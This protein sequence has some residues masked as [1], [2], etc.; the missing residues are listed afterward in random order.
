M[1]RRLKALALASALLLLGADAARASG[2]GMTTSWYVDQFGGEA[3]D[4]SRLYDGR[5]G[6]VMAR[7]PRPQLY[8]AWRLLHGQKVGQAA[9]EALSTPCCDPPW[10]WR[11][12]ISRENVGVDGWLKARALVPG[13]PEVGYITTEREGANYTTI[14]NC[15]DEAFD[16]ASATLKDRAAKYGADSPAVKAWL[17]TQDAVF[18]ACHA[19]GAALPV[20]IADAPAWLKADRAYQEAAFDLYQG[21][22]SDAAVRFAAIAKDRGSPWRPLA[23]YLRTRALVRSAVVEKTA[24]AF[25]GARAAIGELAKAPGGTFG[26]GEAPKMRRMLD[27]R[28]RPR[29]LMAE[30]EKE[31]G[32]RDAVSD[33]AVGFRDYANLYD[34]GTAPSEAMD[35]IATIRA[36][37]T[38]DAAEAAE[39][40]G[41]AETYAQ[42][43][44]RTRREALAHARQRWGATHDP[45]W[46][47][48]G[49]ALTDPGA[50]EAADLA[51]AAGKVPA[52]SPA[53]LS[54]QYH[55]T[56]LTMGGAGA[57]ATRARL[58]AVLARRDLSVNDRNLFLAQRAQVAADAAEFARFAQRR[59]ICGDDDNKGG[60]VRGFWQADAV[61][62]AGVY[63]GEGYAGALGFG[64]D[65][66]A[67]IDRLPLKT[68][69]ALGRDAQLPAR[70]RLDIALTN[71]ARA[72]VLGD[73]A[74]VDGLMGDLQTLL[75]Q[76]AAEWRAIRA[77]PAGPQKRF[78]EFFVLAKV[79]G[80]RTDLVDYIRPE[81]TVAQFQEPW[82]NWVVLP[83]GRPVAPVPPP[84][85]L[86]Q[87]LGT[88]V[89]E[90]D[91]DTRTDLSCL[92]EC[93]DG[94]APL[95]LPDFA[96]AG[97]A[98]A[99]T[100]RG[101]FYRIRP[102][103]GETPEALPPGA[104]AV[105]DEMLAFAR[106]NP[107]HPQVPEA[108]YWIIRAGR[109]GGSHEH[110]GR[111]AFELL[112]KA[113][114]G[115]VWAKRSPYYY[116]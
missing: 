111:R 68:R 31:L 33:I 43:A 49:L 51:E 66:R 112:H 77:A 46:L 5:L 7:S 57:A 110:S 65:A 67:V 63:D 22:N 115:S 3:A 89:S 39:R 108:L 90:D 19:S 4:L 96:A 80:L 92:G 1:A 61:Q 75:P 28:D 54:A 32:Q 106:A 11:Y 34:K 27:F 70:L 114:P 48:A 50:P 38:R 93:G 64:E 102:S 45:A 8:I 91:P 15:F 116:D 12:D 2:P 103:Y 97:A 9:G 24:D 76:L 94:V 84:L 105:W 74:T 69:L 101:Y 35:W 14:A 6:V 113:Y 59:R 72:V 13:A 85:A 41:A 47:V 10:R 30:L 100:E 56:R 58:D 88:G 21:R 25:A 18:D 60:C 42:L 95:R 81:G 107:K 78:A 44:A 87:Q 16:T 26:Q 99:R 109:W 73:H 36:A 53:W 86:Y 40:E 104:M 62:P 17:A 82:T 55:L 20:P 23:P 37:P 79:P 83:Q 71:Y 98:Q 29:Q 52:A